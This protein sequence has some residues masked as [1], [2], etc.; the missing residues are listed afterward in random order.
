MFVQMVLAGHKNLEQN[1]ERVNALN[2]FPVPDGD[3]GTNMSLSMTSGVNELRRYINQPLYRVA[4][5]V[6][7]G[8]LMG[9]RGNSGVIL[10]QLYR[11]FSKAIA[12]QETVDAKKFAEALQNGVTTAYST[13]VKP[14]EGTI[15]H[16]CQRCGK[17]S[18][19][20]YN[21]PSK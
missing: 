4:E 17:S 13:V 7:T 9:A 6:S 16:S 11:G 21:E 3:T 2:V 14:I 20:T 19:P 10:S 12:K 8:L 5:A 18:G 15:A 1:K